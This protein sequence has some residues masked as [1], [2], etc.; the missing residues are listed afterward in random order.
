MNVVVGRADSYSVVPAGAAEFLACRDAW[1]ALAGGVRYPSVFCGWEWTATWWEHYG[2]GRELRLLM[3]YRNG[4]L[5]G[6]LP[7]FLQRQLAG[8]NGRVGR[9]LGYCT[10]ADLYPDPLD[11]VCAETDAEACIEAVLAYLRH[12]ARDWDVLHLRF[13]TEDG[14][15]LRSM[16]GARGYRART[17]QISAAPY[18]SI[19]G[20]YDDYLGELSANERSNIRRRR[21]KLIEGQGAVYTDFRSD[22]AQQVLHTLFELHEKRAAE[23]KIDSSFARVDVFTFHR[24]LLNRLDRNRV[25]LRGLRQNNEIVAVFYG[26][27]AGGRVSY[28]Q[29]GYDPHWADFS[30]GSVLLQETI[31]EAFDRGLTEYNFLQGEEEFK[32]RWTQQARPLYAV[33]LFNGSLCGQLSMSLTAAKHLLKSVKKRR[34]VAISTKNRTVCGPWGRQVRI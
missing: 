32:Y 10:A 30:P 24:D 34:P 18:I 4:E 17:E 27:I 29:L 22:D 13:L 7:L 14:H 26:F 20:S 28:Y 31:R 16:G 15:L 2:A 9:V 6:I 19:K 21:R 23:K 25:W 12:S 1:N 11:I 8:R 5:K 33:D 3:I